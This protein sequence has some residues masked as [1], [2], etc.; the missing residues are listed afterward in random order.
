MRY[1]VTWSVY[2]ED[3]TPEQAARQALAMLQ[4]KDNSAIAFR[5]IEG[6]GQRVERSWFFDLEYPEGEALIPSMSD[7]LPKYLEYHPEKQ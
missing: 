1:T 4:D 3:D 2:L 7:V 6:E 5:V